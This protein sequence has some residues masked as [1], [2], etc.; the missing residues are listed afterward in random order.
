VSRGVV[1]GSKCP[2][3]D[4]GILIATVG[5]YSTPTPDGE[6][7]DVP[8]VRWFTCTHCGEES[9]PHEACRKID[10]AIDA[11]MGDRVTPNR[12]PLFN[13]SLA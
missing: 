13:R 6:Y 1:S 9:L 4:E 10:D 5:T 2:D 11:H 7:I 3:C 12:V 8:D